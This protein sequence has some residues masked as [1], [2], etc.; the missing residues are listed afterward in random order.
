MWGLV[1]PC[2]VCPCLAM[3][4]PCF[5]HFSHCCDNVLAMF[6]HRSDHVLA[7][8]GHALAICWPVVHHRW[9]LGGCLDHV[10]LCW[11]SFN[12]FGHLHN[13][14]WHVLT[15]SGPFSTTAWPCWGRSLKLSGHF[16]AI[17]MFGHLLVIFWPSVWTHRRTSY[18]MF[19]RS[20]PPAGTNMAQPRRRAK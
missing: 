1:W 5:G 13:L 8:C 19:P 2:V 7:T 17:S 4:G 15:M 3:S 10:W 12:M 18:G 11:T 16:G 6:D 14:V 20:H 9:P